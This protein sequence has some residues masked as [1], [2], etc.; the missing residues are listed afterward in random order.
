VV[1]DVEC[2]DRVRVTQLIV[3]A[4]V[5]EVVSRDGVLHQLEGG[6]IQSLSWTLQESAPILQGVVDAQGWADYPIARFTEVPPVIAD[7]IDRP[8]EPF[9]G[10]GEAAA[11]PTGAAIANAVTAALGVRIAELPLTPTAI[12]RALR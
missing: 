8:G 4:D 6:A 1:A 2:I 12:M 5:G 10:A 11:G 9:L 7:V 3:V